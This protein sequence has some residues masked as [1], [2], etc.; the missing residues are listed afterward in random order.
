MKKT[1]MSLAAAIALASVVQ[2]GGDVAPMA[3][4]TVEKS[5]LYVGAGLAAVST[6]GGDLDWFSGTGGQDRLGALVGILGYRF[7]RYIALEGRG[8]ID[9]YGGDFTDIADFSLFLKPIYPVTEEWELY[10]LLGYGWVNIDGDGGWRDIVNTGTFQWGL[11]TSY[12]FMNR[13]S[14]F[15]DYAWLLNDET[16]DVPMPDGSPDVSQDMFTMGVT[17]RF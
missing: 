6:Y 3:P 14:V 8:S 16:A 13:W 4:V 17:Y 1:M 5:G 7:N 10:A 11:G 15:A 2:A 9:I 12:E